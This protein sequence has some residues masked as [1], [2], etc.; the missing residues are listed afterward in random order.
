MTEN[1]NHNL[2]GTASEAMARSAMPRITVGLTCFNAEQTIERALRSALAQ[3]WPD[4]EVVVVDDVSTDD[5]WQVINRI[6]NTDRRVKAVRHA[7]N[8]GPATARNTILE[9]ATGEFVAF[10]DDDDESVPARVRMQ[11]E[12]LHNYEMAHDTRLVACYASGVRRYPNGYE[13]QA[14]A[15]G[16]RWLA[17]QGG[18]VADYLLFNGREKGM[19]Y[20]AGTPTCALMARLSTLRTVGG[21]DSNLRRVEDVDFAIRLALAGGHFIGCPEPLYVQYAT[22]ASDKTPQKNLEA[23]LRLVEK[24]SGYLARKKRYRYARDWFKIRYYHFSG[25]RLVFLLALARFLIRHPVA[26]LQHLLRSAP[27]RIRHEKRMLKSTS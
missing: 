19:F 15:I 21:F 22:V 16:S 5:S 1:G 3:D 8:G 4:L 24:Y 25:Q 18:M 23:E 11:Y 2:P 26:G 27:G 12:A 10:F 20:G 17:P 13:L 9:F 14:S 7:V 6:A